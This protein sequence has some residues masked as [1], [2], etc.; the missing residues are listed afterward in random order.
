MS[1]NCV[2]LCCS[3]LQK[4]F[5]GQTDGSAPNGKKKSC[6]KNAHCNPAI[7]MLFCY[8]NHYWICLRVGHIVDENSNFFFN[9]AHKNHSSNF[10][11]FFP[12]LM[13][14]SKFYIQSISNCCYPEIWEIN[15]LKIW[16]QDV[17][18]CFAKHFRI[19]FYTVLPFCS[20]CVWRYHN[21]CSPFGYIFFNPLNYSW[22]SIQIIHWNIKEALNWKAIIRNITMTTIILKWTIW[23]AFSQ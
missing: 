1:K 22:F 16:I 11:C 13:D 20:P 14:K 2:N 17:L 4:F 15:S 5:C 10:I 6:W 18:I 12:F 3:S 9:F 21:S 8:L 19:H 23:P 7:V